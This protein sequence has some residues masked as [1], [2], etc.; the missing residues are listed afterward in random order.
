MPQNRKAARNKL[1]LELRDK[2]KKSWREIGTIFDLHY[3]TVK[4][5][6]SR[7]IAAKDAQKV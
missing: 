2:R 7:E 3:M 1:I 6:Y 5:I 4:E